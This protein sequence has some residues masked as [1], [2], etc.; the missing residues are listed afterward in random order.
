[1]DLLSVTQTASPD[2]CQ[3]CSSFRRSIF[4]TITP[5]VFPASEGAQTLQRVGFGLIDLIAHQP[6]MG[7]DKRQN[8]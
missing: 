7:D 8:Q 1:M 5:S 3:L 6:R 2:A 4:T